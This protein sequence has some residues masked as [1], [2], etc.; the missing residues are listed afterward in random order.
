MWNKALTNDEIK[1]VMNNKL[2]NIQNQS[3]ILNLEFDANNLDTIYDSSPNK[4]NGRLVYDAKLANY[5][6]SSLKYSWSNADT[7]SAT[8]VSPS[9]T[10]TYTITLS[11]NE[12]SRTENIVVSIY[13][14]N[15]TVSDDKIIKTGESLNITA[16]GAEYYSWSNGQTD[17]NVDITAST[18]TTYYVTGYYNSTLFYIDSVQVFVYP[19]IND[20]TIL[21]GDTVYLNASFN[22]KS[23]N[24]SDSIPY[25]R[26]YIPDN[27]ALQTSGNI[28]IEM[29]MYNYGS[30]DTRNIFYKNRTA[31]GVIWLG[32]ASGKNNVL[33]YQYGQGGIYQSVVSNSSI[34]INKWTHIALVRNFNEGKLYWYINGKL[35]KEVIANYTYSATS[36]NPIFIGYS[37]TKFNGLLDEFRIWNKA[38]TKAEINDVMNN[39]LSVI[40]N[41]NTI[42][43][44]EF[45][46]N[47]SDTI[48]D[49]SPN[50][51]N[52]RLVYDAK[53]TNYHPS[54]LKYS[55]SNTDTTSA[56][57]VSPSITTTYT[58]TL[59][60]GNVSATEHIVVYIYQL[61]NNIA[62]SL[63][64]LKSELNIVDGSNFVT[65]KSKNFNVNIYPNPSDG[66]VNIVCHKDI[67]DNILI[68]VY[69]MVGTELASEKINYYSDSFKYKLNLSYL[70]KGIYI[71]YVSSNN[72]TECYKIVIK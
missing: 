62:D 1:E 26:A 70:K 3:T 68:K 24:L 36:T 30:S 54:L 14:N 10:T 59:S 41:Q 8:N 27:S 6:P 48:Y 19:E 21:K 20:K 71:I 18:N 60:N 12:V 66:N 35:D 43:N 49:S 16:T 23:L 72:N 47:N 7:M 11:K 51:I 22:K 64:D 37:G 29:W 67:L 34:A 38:L 2:S 58:L 46:E 32:N 40:Q 28:T 42:L 39:K 69:D 57:N 31:E 56:T 53:L 5:H 65:S 25:S 61:K 44:I 45:D 13:Q 15:F 4:I 63:L 50:K 9:I 17:S 52:G 33:V 55:W